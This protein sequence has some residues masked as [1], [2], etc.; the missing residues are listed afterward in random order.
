MR[1]ETSKGVSMLVELSERQA[2]TVRTVLLLRQRELAK[3]AKMFGKTESRKTEI[4]FLNSSL[5]A[6][7]KRT[8]K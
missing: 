1:T 8:R 6:L 4:G 3:L 2:D 5:K 7:G